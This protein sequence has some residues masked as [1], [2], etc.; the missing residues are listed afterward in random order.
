M[1]KMIVAIV[2]LMLVPAAGADVP[3]AIP[4]TPAAVDEL[5]SA[6]PFQ[7]DEGF[8]YNW[9]VER[10][11]VESGVIL[12]IK[13]DPALVYPRQIA[14][15]VLYVGD[16]TAQRL[17][18]GDES[19]YVVALVPGDVDLTKTPIWFGTPELPERV[20]ADMAKAERILAD[21]AGIRPFSVDQVQA[22]Q[23]R[24][25]APMRMANMTAL[26]APVATLIEEYSPAETDLVTSY[27][28]AATTR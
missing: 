23:A 17:N 21:R 10:P 16:H 26:L 8:E 13:V 9:S 12:V 20:D 27:R 28:V 22:A 11:L 6:R 3:P 4:A 1:K 5:V 2:A 14:E 25:G 18:L 7:L 15:P 19:G 24:G